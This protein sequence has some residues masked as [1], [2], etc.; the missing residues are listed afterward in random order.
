MLVQAAWTILRRKA[1]DPLVLW[2]RAITER[3]GKRIAVVAVARRLAGI[4]W[5]MWRDGTVYEAERLGFA[6]AAGLKRQAQGIEFQ[7]EALTRAAKKIARRKR[8]AR[9]TSPRTGGGETQE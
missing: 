3:R 8:V 2:G 5:A 9:K 6:S 4:L 7:A 1:E